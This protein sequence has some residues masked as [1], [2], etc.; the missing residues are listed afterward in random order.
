MSQTTEQIPNIKEIMEGERNRLTELKSELV[1]E[2]AKID[3]QLDAVNRYFGGTPVPSRR[4]PLQ[5]RPSIQP[6]ERHPRGFV[7]ETVLKSITEHPS[8][9][10]TGEIIAMLKPQGIG[11][12]S[13]ANAL[14]AL[15]AS[16]KIISEGRGGKYQPATDELPT[17]PAEPSS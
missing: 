4:L 12:Q 2:L 10:T 17:A 8:G 5:P 13:I 15:T 14:G 16:K 1:N 11:Q 7:Q 3:E 6:G 9:M